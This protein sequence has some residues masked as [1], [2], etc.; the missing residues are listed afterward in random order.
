M[1]FEDG[2]LYAHNTGPFNEEAMRLYGKLRRLAYERWQLSGRWI[3]G[4]AS[5]EGSALM[6]P[7]AFADYEAGLEAFLR[8]EHRL[9]AVAWAAEREL[10]G[11]AFMQE[12]F[13]RLYRAYGMPFR[14]FDSLGEAKAWIQPQVDAWG[15][16]ARPSA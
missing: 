15:R 13:G 8:S 11:M 16:A 10:E 12:R 3:A 7:Q 2:V 4:I 14:V 6:S 5:W 9:I 1:R